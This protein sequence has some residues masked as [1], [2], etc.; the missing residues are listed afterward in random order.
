MWLLVY[1]GGQ[2]LAKGCCY[3]NKR[4]DAPD[5]NTEFHFIPMETINISVSKL[6]FQALFQ[7]F[8]SLFS[9]LERF[10]H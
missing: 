10:L 6:N 7:S 2:H 4:K 9:Q 1:V 5:V 3:V 8:M